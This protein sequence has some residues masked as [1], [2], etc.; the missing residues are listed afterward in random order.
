MELS[1]HTVLV[2]GGASGIGLGLAERFLRSRSDVLICGRREDKLAEVKSKYPSIHTRVCDLA[3]ASDRIALVDWALGTCPG[4]DVL[5]NN[6]G[7]QRRVDLG[8]GEPWETTHEEIAIN[9]EAQVHLCTLLVAHLERR[10][11]P[12]ILNVTSGLAFVPLASAPIYSA[13]K[14]AL[15]SFTL[16]LRHQLSKTNI[17]VIEIAPPAVK[18]DLGGPG[19]HEHGVA[20]SEFIDAVVAKLQAGDLE[21]TYGFSDNAS[22]ASREERDQIFTRLNPP[23]H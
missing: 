17:T 20:L 18:T 3:D 9:L 13:T 12:A 15:R 5:V 6:A 8:K 11:Q 1:A 19:L 23:G 7:I 21:I 22:N 4:L 14:A 2:T 10:K 16:S